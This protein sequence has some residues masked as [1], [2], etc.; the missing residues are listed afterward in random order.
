MLK[1]TLEVK[2]VNPLSDDVREPDTKTAPPKVAL[3]FMKMEFEM[4]LCVRLSKIAPPLTA[5]LSMKVQLSTYFAFER[6]NNA[7]PFGALLFVKTESRIAVGASA[8]IAPPSR[9]EPS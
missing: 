2:F 9:E 7:P 1:Y 6:I 3:L 8:Q 5:L 4:M